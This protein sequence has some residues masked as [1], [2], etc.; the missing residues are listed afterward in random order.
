MS[1][2]STRHL[3]SPLR[4]A[5]LPLANRMVMAPMTRS[6][7]VGNVPN[8]LMAEYYGQ[9]AGA[10]LIITEG[11]SP[12]PH[13]LGYA[14]IPGIFTEA[15]VEGW[16]GITDG[17]HSRGGRIFLQ[18]MDTGR[19]THPGNLPAGGV[20]RAPSAVA[21][22]D[23]RVWVD[24]QGNLPVPPPRAMTAEDIEEALDAFVRA[25]RNAV[26]GGFDG[27]ELHGASGYLIEQFL[28]PHSN[29][30]EDGWGGSIEGRTRFLLEVATRTAEAIGPERVGLRLSPYCRFN[31]MPRFA[32]M[33][34]TYDRIAEAMAELGLAYL[35]VIRP[36]QRDDVPGEV[37][38]RIAERFAGTVIFAGNYDRDS[39]ERELERGEAEFIS[40]A[41]AFLANPDLVERFEANAAL[42]EP[43]PSTFYSAGREGY[44]DYPTLAAEIGAVTGG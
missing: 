15:Q 9:R 37:H 41:R 14:R 21:L 23:I 4:L 42:N 38:R 22:E 11:A 20:V 40:F 39:A 17:V 18:L 29:R 6:R 13:G 33:E 27:V 31:E 44:T 10:G 7:A 26:R 19:V 32:G 30:R 36:P 5:G 8:A 12:T 3:L 2:P 35:H 25:A 16:R 28:N 1:D 43:D 34:E 24:G